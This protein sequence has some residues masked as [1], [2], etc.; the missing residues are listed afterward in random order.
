[1]QRTKELLVFG[2]AA[3]AAYFDTTITFVYALLLGFAFN[4]LAGLRADEVRLVMVRFPFFG[5]MNFKGSKFKDSLSE[6]TIIFLVT[7]LLK[8]IVDLMH[9]DDKSAYAVQTLISVAVYYYFTNGLRNLRSAY[10]QNRWIRFLYYFIS[11][12]F[13]ELMPGAVTEAVDKVADECGQE[14]LTPKTN[15]DDGAA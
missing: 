2:V 10:P 5:L 1:M 12:K 7:Y 9:F 6:L 8:A 4:I 11:F 14:V 13:R 15:E 3:V